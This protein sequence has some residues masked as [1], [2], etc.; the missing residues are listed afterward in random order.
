MSELNVPGARFARNNKLKNI[1]HKVEWLS[2]YDTY[3]FKLGL[4]QESMK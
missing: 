1:V 4:Y 3:M 2:L